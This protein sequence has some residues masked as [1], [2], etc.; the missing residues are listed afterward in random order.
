M[1]Q[2]GILIVCTLC[3]TLYNVLGHIHVI[4]WGLDYIVFL[5]DGPRRGIDVGGTVRVNVICDISWFVQLKWQPTCSRIYFLSESLLAF[6]GLLFFIS[7]L[8]SLFF[9]TSAL[10][11][12]YYSHKL[13]VFQV[14]NQAHQLVVLCKC[15]LTCQVVTQSVKS[16][17]KPSNSLWKK[18]EKMQEW[19]QKEGDWWKK[20]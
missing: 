18:K 7:T 1:A 11:D 2:K 4:I 6:F 17:R 15:Q 3:K 8:I 19:K 10:I 13:R 16:I 9:P 5:R 20:E 12:V 14:K